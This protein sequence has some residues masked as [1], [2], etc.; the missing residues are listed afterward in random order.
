MMDSADKGKAYDQAIMP[1][2]MLSQVPYFQ[3]ED[4]RA[5]LPSITLDDMLAY[6]DALKTNARPEF[7]VVGNLTEQQTKD[8]AHGVQ[9]TGRERQRM[10][11]QQRRADRQTAVSDFR[12]SGQQHRFRAGRR[13]CSVWFR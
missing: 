5:L 13:V 2:Q 9:E 1:V 12:K 11:S 7:L 6:R 10:V 3:R 8:L 4:R